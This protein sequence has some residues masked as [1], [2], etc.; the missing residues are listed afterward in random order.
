MNLLQISLS[1]FLNYF[2]LWA[3][4]I[5]LIASV[6]RDISA[7]GVIRTKM[8]LN[9]KDCV[10]A[11]LVLYAFLLFMY[12]M[13]H[14]SQNIE[15]PCR[16]HEPCV[17]FCCIDRSSCKDSFIRDHF[18]SSLLKRFYYDDDNNDTVNYVILHGRPR[19]SLESVTVN[20]QFSY[21]RFD[22]NKQNSRL[23][24][25]FRIGWRRFSWWPFQ[26]SCLLRVGFLLPTRRVEGE[27]KNWVEATGLQHDLTH[28]QDSS[29]D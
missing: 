1:Q 10:V 12:F 13:V 19:C 5:S 16:W 23:K 17:R 26:W 27:R 21:V 28:L 11:V 14:D 22:E 2:V 15:K 18:D 8:F 29:V 7:R 20:W 4:E 25:L 3:T 9:K 24:L 6:Y